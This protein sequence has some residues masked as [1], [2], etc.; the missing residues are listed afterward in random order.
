[1]ERE[2]D[3]FDFSLAFQMGM[4]VEQLFNTLSNREYLM[5]RAYFVYKHAMD[6]LDEKKLDI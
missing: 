4:S 6:E 3:P 5:W 2:L 1:M